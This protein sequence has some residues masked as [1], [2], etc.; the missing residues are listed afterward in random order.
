MT[1]E[2][3]AIKRSTLQARTAL[4]A[5]DKAGRDALERAYRVAAADLRVQIETAGGGAGQVRLAQLRQVLDQVEARLVA[6]AREG[7]EIVAEGIAKAA[8]YGAAGAAGGLEAGVANAA[9]MRVAEEAVRFVQHFVAAD[10]LQLS[11][12]LWRI[13]RGARDAV[14]NAVERAVIQGQGAADAMRDFLARGQAVPA[15]V[16]AK[17]GEAQAGRIARAA[18]Q[19]LVSKD[20]AA[21]NAMRV[22]RTEINRAHGEAYMAGG[23]EK[24]WFGGWKFELS[25]QHP[26]HDVCDLLAEQNLYGLGRGVYPSREKCPWPAHPNTISFIT[27]VWKDEITA[28]DRAGKESPM[29]ALARLPEEVRKGVL[30]A[31]KAEVFDQGKLRQGMIRAPLRAVR[32]RIGK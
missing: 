20:G 23:E 10:G 7:R 17:A 19:A 18:E 3:A 1:P 11:D 4:K 15:D 30:G 14:V 31:G 28:A 5:L 24:P 13:D 6:L 12:R 8:Q 32:K 27:M 16:T 25:P 29:D 2:K 26:E 9:A 21:S 22:F